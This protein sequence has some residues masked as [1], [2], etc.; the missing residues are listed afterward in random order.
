MLQAEAIQPI[1]PCFCSTVALTELIL[2]G[3]AIFYEWLIAR[4]NYTVINYVKQ[5][6]NSYFLHAVTFILR[7]T[8]ATVSLSISCRHVILLLQ[9]PMSSCLFTAIQTA[10][11]KIL[12]YHEWLDSLYQLTMMNSTIGKFEGALILYSKLFIHSSVSC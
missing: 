5:R 11:S 7:I 9:L 12:A 3:I 6:A 1:L 2:I 10:Y 4:A 8:V